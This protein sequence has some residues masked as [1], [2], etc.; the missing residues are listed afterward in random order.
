MLGLGDDM[1]D[2]DD[3]LEGTGNSS[4]KKSSKRGK[5]KGK[6]M[7]AKRKGR[8]VGR[9]RRQSAGR[10]SMSGGDSDAPGGSSSKAHTTKGRMI[11]ASNSHLV[12][13]Q[14]ATKL[15]DQLVNLRQDF[16]VAKLWASC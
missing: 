2:D 10:E 16:F 3:D 1:D 6:A 15:A 9:V 4:G 7:R 14:L 13:D 12:D 8:G 11:N 5:K